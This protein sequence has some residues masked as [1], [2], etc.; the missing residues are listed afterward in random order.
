MLSCSSDAASAMSSDS[1]Y[2]KLFRSV[3]AKCTALTIAVHV[4]S[5]SAEIAQDL[6]NRK[7]PKPNSTR[8]NSEYDCF[9]RIYEVRDKVGVVIERLKLPKLMDHEM[10]FLGE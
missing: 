2:K 4:S 6:L 8:W 3:T 5:K 1:Q 10:D 9:K 7:I